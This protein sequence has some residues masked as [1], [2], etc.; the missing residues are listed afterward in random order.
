[1]P[2]PLR[3][4]RIDYLNVWHVFQ[5]LARL[6]P[7]GRGCVHLPGHPSELNRALREGRL[8]VSPSSSFEYLQGAEHYRLLAGHGICARHQ[9]QSVLMLSPTPLEELGRWMEHHPGPVLVSTASAT[10]SAL[11]R[12]LWHRAWRLPE[13]QW[14]PCPPGHGLDTGRPHLEIGNIALER[15][16]NPPPGWQVIDLATAWHHFTGLPFVFAV[17]IVRAASIA[18]HREAITQLHE[19]LTAISRT[20][21]QR[22][23]ELAPLAATLHGIPAEAVLAYWRTMHSDLGPEEQAALTCFGAYATEFGLLRGMPTLRWFPEP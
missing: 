7:E 2:L 22:L 12:I 20:L 21:P 10:S 11:L 16:L 13:P 18:E 3:L 15:W 5:L 8:D 9:V 14:Q 1:M 6:L 19:A 23:P 17:W 4:G